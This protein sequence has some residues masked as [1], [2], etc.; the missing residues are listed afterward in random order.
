[1]H[2][3]ITSGHKSISDLDYPLQIISIQ[4]LITGV[5]AHGDF[6]L[7]SSETGGMWMLGRR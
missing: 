4:L 3:L 6:C 2:D 7:I 5:W 1:M